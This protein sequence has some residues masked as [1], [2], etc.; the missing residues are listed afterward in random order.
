MRTQ[1]RIW[2]CTSGSQRRTRA[3]SSSSR[4]GSSRRVVESPAALSPAPRRSTLAAHRAMRSSL[5]RCGSTEETCRRFSRPLH[6]RAH[7]KETTQQHHRQQQEETRS[8]S[9]SHLLLLLLLIVLELEQN[10]TLLLVLPNHRLLRLIVLVMV[11]VMVRVR[12][13]AAAGER[14]GCRRLCSP[15]RLNPPLSSL[16][17]QQHQHGPIVRLILS[18]SSSSVSDTCRLSAACRRSPPARPTSKSR[19]RMRSVASRRRPSRRRSSNNKKMISREPPSSKDLLRSRTRTSSNHSHSSSSSKREVTAGLPSTTSSSHPRTLQR[20]SIS[21]RTG[22]CLRAPSTPEGGRLSHPPP[23]P[24]KSR[25]CQCPHQDH[26][27]LPLRHAGSA[28]APFLSLCSKRTKTSAKTNTLSRARPH[29]PG[30]VRVR[31]PA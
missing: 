11:M 24:A 4:L 13:A 28:S 10:G 20:W 1:T 8:R 23:P 14:T 7:K 31:L 15:T 29:S 27:R 26:Q 25:L 16:S 12:V 3:S 9:S 21:L 30:L 17:H 5:R 2:C 18:S 19:I 22:R 6:S